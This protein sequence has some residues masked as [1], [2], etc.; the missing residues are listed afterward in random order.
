MFSISLVK[1]DFWSSNVFGFIRKN[2]EFLNPV[3]GLKWTSGT[4]S[5]SFFCR[6][7]YHLLIFFVFWVV[8]LPLT[9]PLV[10]C[11]IKIINEKIY[12]N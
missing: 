6:Y 2:H 8:R 3:M 10:I 5:S 4:P 1:F 7:A 9:V 12:K 11:L